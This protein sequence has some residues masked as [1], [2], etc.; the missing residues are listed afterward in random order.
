MYL[1]ELGN[2][3]SGKKGSTLFSYNKPVYIIFNI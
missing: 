3:K 2:Y 1:D